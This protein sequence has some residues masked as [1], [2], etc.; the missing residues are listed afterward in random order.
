M[1][2]EAKERLFD[3]SDDSASEEELNVFNEENIYAKKYNDW[4]RKEELQK[5]K[6]KYGDNLDIM[7]EIEDSE[8]GESGSDEDEDDES[9]S[10]E[11]L[12][13]EAFDEQ[14]LK[15]YSALKSKAPEIYEKSFAV[16][17]N[18]KEEKNAAASSLKTKEKP[19]KFTLQD[20]HHKLIKEKKGITEE[21]E[22]M[23]KSDFNDDEE[24]KPSGYYEELYNIRQE[25]NEIVNDDEGDESDQLFSVKEQQPC[26][27]ESHKSTSNKKDEFIS[28]IWSNSK[29]TDKG[30]EFLKD[31]I[32]NKR[33]LD[34]KPFT[35]VKK[36]KE[37]D[38]HFGGFDSV[39]DDEESVEFES[40]HEEGESD[41]SEE[42]SQVQ[43]A[44][45]HYEEPD[46]NVIKRYPRAIESIRDTIN[47]EKKT[48]RA[49]ARE[50]KKQEKQ[51]ELK[52]LRKL[53]REE[54][55]SR[56]SKLKKISGNQNIDIN[57]L[58]LNV[59]ID[60]ENDFDMEKYDQKMQLLFGDS[61]YN[62]GDEEGKPSFEYIPEIDDDLYDDGEVCVTI[63]WLIV[64]MAN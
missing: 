7:S 15:V 46:A 40:E 21:D 2:S 24:E 57:D 58:D 59:I 17:S 63:Y 28:K 45:H 33:Y 8:G 10:S 34:S 35:T 52:R 43:V 53:K 19:K 25:I 27:S 29:K 38:T 51:A 23:M 13:E 4:R 14:F 60:D 54:T 36:F 48:R 42:E 56:V 6:D 16:A 12:S 44:K 32:V 37:V 64:R 22:Q 39:K 3:S 50:A 31:Y 20:Y 30:E 9:D 1:A 62:T 55:E 26:S 49:E 41:A 11:S 61:Y 18:D 5:L 47:K